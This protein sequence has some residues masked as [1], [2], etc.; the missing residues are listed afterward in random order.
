MEVELEQYDDIFKAIEGTEN[1]IKRN[2][3]TRERRVQDVKF[4]SNNGTH[5]VTIVTVHDKTVQSLVKFIL[6]PFET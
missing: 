6:E 4:S 2:M 3:H 1:T 5:Y